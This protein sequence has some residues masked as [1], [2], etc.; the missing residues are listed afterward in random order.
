MPPPSPH[1]RRRP[2]PGRSRGPRSGRLR[3]GQRNAPGDRETRPRAHC[4]RREGRTRRRGLLAEVPGRRSRPATRAGIQVRDHHPP[5][6]DDPGPPAPA[7]APLPAGRGPTLLPARPPPV[8]RERPVGSRGGP[9]HGSGP[10][11]ARR[12]E[13]DPPPTTAAAVIG[14]MGRADLSGDGKTSPLPSSN[15]RARPSTATAASDSGT[16]CSRPPFI[17]SPGIRHSFASK[18]TSAQV[19]PRASPDRAAV[20]TRKRRQRFTGQ[21]RPR[22]LHGLQGGPNLPEGPRPEVRLDGRHGRQ[23]ALDSFPGHVL[24]DVAMR[25]AQPQRGVDPLLKAVSGRTIR[26][27][28]RVRRSRR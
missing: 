12:P 22:H 13:D 10:R 26:D 20:S 27:C 16:R 21:T 19:A 11:G 3:P 23:R 17:R 25:P 1:V 2:P 24:L 4:L 28:E 5:P 14:E 7:P 9:R 18:S 15:P 6:H 8:L